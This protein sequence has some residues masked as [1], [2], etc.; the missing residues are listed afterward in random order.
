MV[1]DG[2]RWNVSCSDEEEVVK[3]GLQHIR[4]GD[5]SDENLPVV[6]VGGR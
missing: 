5:R 1:G 6:G 3:N 2:H 4:P